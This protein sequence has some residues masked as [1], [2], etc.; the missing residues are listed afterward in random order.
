MEV[1]Q[2]VYAEI[3]GLM[4]RLDQDN[5]SIVGIFA[6]TQNNYHFTNNLE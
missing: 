6:S 5:Y 2:L 3:T 4:D 1:Y